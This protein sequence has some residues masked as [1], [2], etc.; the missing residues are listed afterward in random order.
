MALQ[1]IGSHVAYIWVYYGNQGMLPQGRLSASRAMAYPYE[2]RPTTLKFGL[3]EPKQDPNIAY[4]ITLCGRKPAGTGT[5]TPLPY[6][7][8]IV[9]LRLD[10]RASPG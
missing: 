4:Q 3:S 10:T 7:R 5:E 2:S 9:L 1:P 8:G 6:N